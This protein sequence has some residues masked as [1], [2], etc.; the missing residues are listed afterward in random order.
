MVLALPQPMVCR[1]RNKTSPA[2]GRAPAKR[3]CRVRA[4]RSMS[5]HNK[6]VTT[7]IG[8]AGGWSG[9][10]FV[11]FPKTPAL[12]DMVVTATEP[13]FTPLVVAK[14]L[15]FTEHVVARAGTVQEAVTVEENPNSD[16]TAMSFMYCAVCPAVTV[17]DVIPRSATVKSATRFSAT[18]VEFDAV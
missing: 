17:C 3:S 2:N 10:G 1:M 5:A 13:I 6:R 8:Q 14:E 7:A 9:N 18:A 11:G 16:V 12:R 4:S 15:G